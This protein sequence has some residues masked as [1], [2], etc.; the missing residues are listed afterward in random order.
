MKVNDIIKKKPY[1]IWSTK[2][3]DSL[4]E[5]SVVEAVLN[6]G[7]WNDFQTLITILGIKKPLPYL[8]SKSVVGE[9]TTNSM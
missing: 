6:Y 3:Y 7:D 5:E 4:S 2:D 1:L 8:E 9:A